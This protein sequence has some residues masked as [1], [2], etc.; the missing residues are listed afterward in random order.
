[1][2]YFIFKNQTTKTTFNR[3]YLTT[4]TATT[5]TTSRKPLVAKA[6]RGG[7]KESS[8]TEER[9]KSKT[10]RYTVEFSITNATTHY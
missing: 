2:D 10:P 5:T 4:T 7:L 1:M 6:N 3:I 9:E 8:Q